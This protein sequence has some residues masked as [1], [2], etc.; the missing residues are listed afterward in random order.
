MLN[1]LEQEYGK[2]LFALQKQ[3]KVERFVYEGLILKIAASC[4]Y[5]PDYYIIR[6]D[7][8]IELHEVK[9]MWRDDARVKIKTAAQLYPEFIFRAVTKKNNKWTWELFSPTLR[10]IQSQDVYSQ[11]NLDSQNESDD[12]TTH[13]TEPYPKNF[14]DALFVDA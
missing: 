7:G 13:K 3:G 12:T 4:T 1:K 6:S 8:Y 9:G 2:Y 10:Y 11:E 5:K 14:D